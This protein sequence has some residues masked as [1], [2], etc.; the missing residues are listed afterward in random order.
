MRYPKDM[1]PECIPLCDALN[2]IP[3]IRTEESCSGHG[4]HPFKIWFRLRDHAKVKF[5]NVVA[6]VFDRR[7]GGMPDWTCE[8]DCSDLPHRTPCFFI[9]SGYFKGERAYDH[10]RRIAENIYYHL[11]HRAFCRAFLR[12]RPLRLRRKTCCS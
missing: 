3:G 10:S 7:Y 6:R 8:L 5:L 1:D 9:S 11:G 4:Q 12:R 2:S